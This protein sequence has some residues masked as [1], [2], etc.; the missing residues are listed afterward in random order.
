PEARYVASEA[1]SLAFVTALQL[2][3]PRQRAVL[4]LRDVLGFHAN[5]AA[6]MLETTVE[7]VTSA[8]K[9]A[10]ATLER[11]LDLANQREPPPAPN[12]P[13]EGEVAARLTRAYETGDVERLVALLTDDVRLA[14]PPIPLEYEGRELAAR[15]HAAVPFRQGRTY[16]LIPTRANGQ[17]AF[18]A[19]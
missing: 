19:Y 17:L 18:G 5:E 9:R 6:D 2:L 10:R 12:S 4:V 8:L 14:M 13:G 1:I 16:R 3:P 11:R 7:S 15:F